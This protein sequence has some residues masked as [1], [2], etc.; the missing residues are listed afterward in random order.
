MTDCNRFLCVFLPKE[1]II[2][3]KERL[4]CANY[5]KFYKILAML[6]KIFYTNKCCGMIV[7][8]RKVAIPLAGVGFYEER[9][10]SRDTDDKSLYKILGLHQ[11]ETT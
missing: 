1:T 7:M 6:H 3:S 8:I 5:K 10:S 9:M 2:L 4:I 11:V